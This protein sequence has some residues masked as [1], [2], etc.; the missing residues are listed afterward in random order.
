VVLL[1]AFAVT[2]LVGMWVAV[3]YQVGQERQGARRD[4]V[5]QSQALSR[6]LSEHVSQI[7]RQSD[8]ATQ[9]FKLKFEETEGAL[10]IAEFRRRNGLLDSVLPSRLDLPI[11]LVDRHGTVIDSANA[12]FPASVADQGSFKALAEVSGG[13]AAMFSN[14]LVE[15]RTHRWLIQVSRRLEDRHGAF[16]GVI[17]ILIDPALFID[18][19]D[20][21]N[22]DERGTLMLMTRDSG[23]TIGRVGEELFIRDDVDFVPAAYARAPADELVPGKP[24]DNVARIYSGS[25]LPRY[26]LFAVVGLAEDRSLARFERHRQLYLGI[27]LAATAMVV[28]VVALLMRQS[29]RL[30][31]SMR[32]ARE[33][34]VTLRA[35][36]EGSLDAFILLKAWPGGRAPISDFIVEDINEKGAALLQTA[37]ADLIGKQVFAMLPRFRE[38]GFF[39]RYKQVVAEGRTLQEEVELRFEG[40][41]PRWIQ[42]QVVPVS[43]GVAITSRE[44]SERKRAELEMRNNRNF[45]H[46]LIDHLPLLVYVK[47][48]RADAFGSMVVW[49]KAAETVTGYSAAQVLG[50]ADSAVFPADFALRNEVEDRALLANP[51]P[52]DLPER[53]LTRPDG[54]LRYLHSV[55]VPLFDEAGVPEYILCIAEDV[56]RRREQE[57]NLRASEAELAAVT[58]ASPLGLVRADVHGNCTYVNRMFETITGLTRERAIGQGWIAAIHPG[59]RAALAGIFHHQRATTAPFKQVVRVCHPDGRLVWTSVKVAAVRIDARIEGFV[60]SIDDITTLREAEMALRESESRLRTIADTLPAMVAY[61]DAGEVYRFHNSAYQREFARDG[62]SVPGM[63][64][65]ETVGAQRYAVL[66]PYIARVLGGETLVFEE[67]DETAGVERTLEVTYIPQLGED[68]AGVVGFHVMRQDITSQK[69]EKKRLLKL[70]QVDALTGL[71]NRAGFL[72]KLNSTMQESADD[73]HLMAVMYMDIDRFK[74]VNDTHGH[75]VGDA[76]LKAFSARLTHTLRASDTIARL[77]GDEFTIIMEKIARPEDAA[78]I[79]AKIVAAMRKPFELSGLSVSVSASI[80]LAFFRG[81]PIDPD[82]LLKQAD[83]LLYQAKQAGRDTYRAA[84]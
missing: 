31:A 32:A 74:P 60:G 18:D 77:G 15:P 37:R 78:T 45:L 12:A 48:V 26:A 44:I 10:R 23:L 9:L 66:A 63:T 81:G 68:G 14:L 71:A 16:A 56:T 84:A 69:R 59:D 54:T 30:R 34:Q 62:A 75:D 2:L 40:E 6:V 72:Q 61:I 36:A 39:E 24:F 35:A 57:Q 76:L 3:F 53:P 11:V 20:R 8:H 13:D 83:T 58:N 19:Y 38:T 50:K 43:D 25:D 41:A 46:S 22:I 65:L 79:A 7:L 49:N 42:H 4:A 70:A 33:A 73:G 5:A 55:S 51:V 27:L 17:I 1:P 21:L 52:V 28:A 80:G 67:H 29:A 82:A 64:I 47:S